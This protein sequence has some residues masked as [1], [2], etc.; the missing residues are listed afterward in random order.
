[1][2]AKEFN[3]PKKDLVIFDIDDTLLHTTAKIRVVK[4]GRTVRELTN[5]QFN[6]YELQPGEA[7]DFGEFRDAEK[8]NRESQPIKP[9]IN[10]L[11]TIL[12]QSPNSEVIMLTARADFDDRDT[13]L[14]TFTDLG[15]DMSRVHVHRAGNL[16]GDDI[17]AEKKA[18]YVRKYADTNKYDHI[19]LYD[20]SKT[21]LSVFKDLKAEYPNIDFRAYYV[22]PSGKTSI[23]E[24][25]TPKERK[26]FIEMFKK[27]L[28]LAMHYLELDSLPKM[29]FE[30]SINDETQPTF[31]RFDNDTNTLYVALANRH[32]ND[33]LRTVAHELQH[34]KQGTEHRLEPD[35]GETGSPIENEA[36]AIA[37]IV[38]R[39]FNKM[40]PEYLSSKPMI[41]ESAVS[42][43][44]K[45]LKNPTGYDAI[46][47]MMKAIAKK[48]N[49]T[50]KELHNKFVE[51]HGEIP[52]DWIKENFADGKHPGRKGDS[53]RHGIPKHASLSKLDKIGHGS[54][55]K[56]QLARWQANMRR[57]RAKAKKK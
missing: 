26:T 34:Y 39:H 14:K 51:K 2:R 4:D 21:N 47:H 17:P 45:D 37:G 27:F 7:F 41:S 49:M 19:R 25:I 28:P 31:G 1:M 13:F 36:H 35:S 38:M 16:P 29:K 57:G 20:D 12:A 53:A 56:A 18:V 44:E 15:I 33:I 11:K 43:L 54:G 10:K 30:N 46:D 3:Q 23:Q 8:F 32:P 48:Y 22:G 50:P 5:Q 40:Y 55:R 6:N 42:D 24:S 9:M 52:D